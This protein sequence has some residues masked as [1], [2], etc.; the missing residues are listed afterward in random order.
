ML[1]LKKIFIVIYI[2]E[3]FFAVKKN[4]LSRIR[5]LVLEREIDINATN[6]Y[7]NTALHIAVGQ[8]VEAV[9]L[10]LE[11]SQIDVKIKN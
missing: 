8:S 5:R 6:C 4:D 10:L 1:F 2:N 11:H 7:G 3:L 9:K